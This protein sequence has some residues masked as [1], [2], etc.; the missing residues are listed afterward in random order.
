MSDATDSGPGP[1]ALGDGWEEVEFER[2][3]YGPDDRSGLRVG[4]GRGSMRVAVE[5]V[6]YERNGHRERIQLLVDGRR[7]VERNSPAAVDA[8]QSATTAY[9][10]LVQYQPGDRERETVYTVTH[11]AGDALAAAVWLT[12]ATDTDW[13]MERNIR[14][15]RGAATARTDVVVSDDDALRA[16]FRGVADR[17]VFSGKPTRSHRIRLPYRYVGALRNRKR[18]G[19]GMLRVP[20]S[21]DA[22]VGAVSHEAWVERELESID[23]AAP[24][25]RPEPGTYR[26]DT[27]VREAIA[28]LD[29]ADFSC[30]WLGESLE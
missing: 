22:L 14:L 26:L 4:L 18:T 6:R 29:A 16:L 21:V 23:W 2:D 25:V 13:S 9:A 5:P 24:I 19:R 8:D 7:T 28:G 3:V 12:A 10:T 27:D 20:S 15:H 1:L 17:C 30:L 11:D